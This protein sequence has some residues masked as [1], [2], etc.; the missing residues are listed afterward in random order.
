MKYRTSEIL[1]QIN[2]VII[3][4]ENIVKKVFMAILAG[5]H[6][7]LEDVPGVGKT[8]LA[9]SF[10]KVLGLDY[11]RIQF[12]SDS[13]PSDVIGFSVYDKTTGKLSYVP[14]A[15]MTNLL[16]ACFSLRRQYVTSMIH[17]RRSKLH[18]LSQD[19]TY[20]LVLLT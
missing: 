5:G 1:D 18:S 2:K 8:T 6:V 11:R 3:G 12:T 17:L 10:S 7:L 13:V 14:G 15:V 4:K 19:L 16:L 20:F 9:L